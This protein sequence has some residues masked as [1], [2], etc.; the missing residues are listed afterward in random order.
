MLSQSL[1]KRLKLQQRLCYKEQT[2]CLV[3]MF[4]VILMKTARKKKK[5][6]S[7]CCSVAAGVSDSRFF[8][9]LCLSTD[10]FGIIYVKT[11]VHITTHTH[12]VGYF[13]FNTVTLQTGVHMR[14]L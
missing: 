13:D 2:Y 5:P 4:E 12:T 11:I 14:V 10:T 8:T 6:C 7:L 1:L 9:N 3:S